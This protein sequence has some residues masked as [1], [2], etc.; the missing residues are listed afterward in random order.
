MKIHNLI[1]R[2][3]RSRG[4]SG[5]IIWK[6]WRVPHNQNHDPYVFSTLIIFP[7]YSNKFRIF[8][9]KN[10]ITSL[11][12][13]VSGLWL[14]YII[15]IIKIIYMFFK[16]NNNNDKKIED[17]IFYVKDLKWIF[18]RHMHVDNRA[19]NTRQKVQKIDPRACQKET[20]T[21]KL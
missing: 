10:F 2:S 3:T 9:I 14:N 8:N 1:G 15:I 7:Y 21:N 4:P 20:K 13:I 11:N 19:Q 18:W 16:F 5:V 12:K 6:R 17:Y